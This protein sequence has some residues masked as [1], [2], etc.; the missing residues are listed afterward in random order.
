MNKLTKAG[1][2][3]PPW[4]T[5]GGTRAR[6]DEHLSSAKAAG[7]PGYYRLSST[8]PSHPLGYPGQDSSNTNLDDSLQD[9]WIQM[10]WPSNG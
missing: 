9:E 4:L 7:A 6:D 3:W 8:P 2:D 1:E 10:L 5:R